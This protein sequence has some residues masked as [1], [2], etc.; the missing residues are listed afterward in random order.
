MSFESE[1]SFSDFVNFPRGIRRSGRFSIKESELLEECGTAMMAIHKGERKPKDA[2]EKQFAD[3]LRNMAVPTD[4]YA[5]V[6]KKYLQEIGPRKT[7]LLTSSSG[8]DDDGS[9]SSFDSSDDNLD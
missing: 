1:K 3:Q 9:D 8:S 5:K 2:T 7:H 6:F 4:P